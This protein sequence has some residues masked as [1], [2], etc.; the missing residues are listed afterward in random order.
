MHE[1]RASG[2]G[3][4]IQYGAALALNSEGSKKRKHSGKGAREL[5]GEPIMPDQWRKILNHFDEGEEKVCAQFVIDVC[6]GKI[7]SAEMALRLRQGGARSEDVQKQVQD[8]IAEGVKNA[9]ASLGLDA[10]T[11]ALLKA[12][13]AVRR[14]QKKPKAKAAPQVA[15][16]A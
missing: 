8:G 12:K 3:T 6:K 9:L 14:S 15:Q 11:V 1:I 10:E 13:A 2:Y 4:H 5:F 7:G 16:P